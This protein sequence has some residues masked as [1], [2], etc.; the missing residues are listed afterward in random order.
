MAYTPGYSTLE[1]QIQTA[2][3]GITGL[4]ALV[5]RG[6]AQ[7]LSVGNTKAVILTPGGFSCEIRGFYHVSLY[8]VKMDIAVRFINDPTTHADFCALRDDVM[9]KL[10]T[11]WHPANITE[12]TVNVWQFLRFAS[13]G[14]PAYIPLTGPDGKTQ[15]ASFLIQPF[16]LF[17]QD[18]SVTRG[19]A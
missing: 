2:L 17:F 13:D 9:G 3:Q 1:G 11:Y 6:D 4:T 16:R 7:V 12:S 15:I 5:K 19:G 8:D 14:D 18:Q 10:T